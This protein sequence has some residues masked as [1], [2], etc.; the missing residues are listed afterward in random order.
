MHPP[1]FRAHGGAVHIGAWDLSVGS[2]FESATDKE[3]VAAA[4]AGV[5][6]AGDVALAFLLPWNASRVAA[7]MPMGKVL[8]R[9]QD[10][11]L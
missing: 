9:V 7:L 5:Q 10:Q 11:S 2:L 1:A 8:P 3:H 6:A 4:V